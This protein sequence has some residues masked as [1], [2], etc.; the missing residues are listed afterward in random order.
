[1]QW[2]KLIEGTLISRYKR[3]MADVKLRNGRVV[4]AHCPN[5]GSMKTCCEPGRRVYISRSDRPG[6][7]LK[8]TWEMIEMPSSLVG[9]NTSVPNKLVRE[10]LLLG[11]LPELGPFETVRS[12]VPYGAG[13]RIDLL[14]ERADG[15]RC[16]IEV[17]NCTLI[18][19][20]AALFPDAV[21]SRGLKHLGELQAM[22]REG[23]DAVSFFLIQRMDASVFRP[24]DG[25]D[26]AYGKELRKAAQN[27][28]KVVAYDVVM[29]L[30][31]I[32][33]GKAIRCEL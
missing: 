14:L 23:H 15:R 3:F 27:G 24:A 4:T 32:S 22:V 5:S 29:D 16:Y 11:M 6:R 10:G 12:E 26:P 18:D 20:D 2:P 9:I 25:I 17:K 28:V 19:H 8:Y 7:R 31:T 13:S 1:V 33:L 30:R 21:T